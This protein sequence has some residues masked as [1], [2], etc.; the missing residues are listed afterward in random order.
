MTNE[1]LQ[2]GSDLSKKIVWQKFRVG[3]LIDACKSDEY[4]IEYADNQVIVISDKQETYQEC[5]LAM[6]QTLTDMLEKEQEKL[7][8]LEK[9]FEEL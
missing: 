8:E 9:E 4:K 6:R 5:F 1:Q 2:Q 3:A 7:A